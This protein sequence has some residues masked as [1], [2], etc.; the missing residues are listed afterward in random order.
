MLKHAALLG[1]WGNFFNV[2]KASTKY[3]KNDKPYSYLYL[4][5][6]GYFL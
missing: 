1:I 2:I 4:M 5:V 3:N 6:N